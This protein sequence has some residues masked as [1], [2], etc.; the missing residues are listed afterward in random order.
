MRAFT[1]EIILNTYLIM[2]DIHYQITFHT[3]WHCGSGLSAGADVD[4]LVVKDADGLPFVPGKT[5]KG[6]LRDAAE[7]LLQLNPAKYDGCGWLACVGYAAKDGSAYGQGSAF[8]ANATLQEQEAETIR[9]QPGLA[10][11]LY[12]N[13]TSTAI[14]ETTGTAHEHSLRKMEV[15]VPCTLKGCIYDVPDDC[16]T[17]LSDSMK[18]VKRLGV[19]RNRGL[20]RCTLA[21]S[22]L[23]ERES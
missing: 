22:T 23:K 16:V 5:M 7:L 15:T 21:V 1:Y 4:A 9:L 6:L 2:K 10:R 20:G 8:F 3:Y 13:V 12:S 11:Y 14:D 18:V 17:L 19:G